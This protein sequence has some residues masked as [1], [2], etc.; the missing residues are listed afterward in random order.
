MLHHS[1]V[2]WLVHIKLLT[3]LPTSQP[4]T[5]PKTLK[6]HDKKRTGKPANICFCSSAADW[7]PEAWPASACTALELNKQ[8]LQ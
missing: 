5:S 7:G 3:T 4:E 8:K 6:T 1:S 2:L